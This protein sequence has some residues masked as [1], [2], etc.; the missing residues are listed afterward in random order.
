MVRR[1]SLSRMIAA[2]EYDPGSTG[3]NAFLS[4]FFSIFLSRSAAGRPK[5]PREPPPNSIDS[6]SMS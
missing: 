3:L 4:A 2:D 5:P 1:P 6:M